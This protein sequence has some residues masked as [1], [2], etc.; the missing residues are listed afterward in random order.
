MVYLHDNMLGH[1][2]RYLLVV[3]LAIIGFI[4]CTKDDPDA[5]IPQQS[6]H[7]LLIYMVATNSLMYDAKDDLKEIMSGM[8]EMPETTAVYVY[9]ASADI[10]KNG[11]VLYRVEHNGELT[12]VRNYDI[13]MSS[14]APT[15]ISGVIEEVKYLSPSETY[16]LVLWSHATG[17]LPSSSPVTPCSFGSDYKFHLDIDLLAQAIPSATFDFI[18]CDCCYMSSV[19]VIYELREK[20]R[21]FIASPTP[22]MQCGMPY[23]RTLPYLIPDPESLKEAARL[24]YAAIMSRTGNKGYS[25]AI[26]DMQYMDDVAKAANPIFTSWVKVSAEGLQSYSP[27]GIGPFYD[28]LQYSQRIASEAGIPDKIRSLEDAMRN[29]V[30]FKLTS[31]QFL[32]LK[33]DDTLFSGMSVH[34]YS[35]RQND[36]EN[37]YRSLSWYKDVFLQH[38]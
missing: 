36:A 10:D 27:D 18:W 3:V 28:F 14:L 33:I 35:E 29:A 6:D 2:N 11:P 24:S 20:C 13:S 5:V 31:S 12:I 34:L 30:I 25:I 9:Y 26:T 17:W 38:E 8:A 22:L 15:R 19:E 7:T 37:F 21:W 16:G 32:G 1:V 4:S 23:D